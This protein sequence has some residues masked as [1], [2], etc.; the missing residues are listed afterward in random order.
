MYST[1]ETHPHLKLWFITSFFFFFL[2]DI[3]IL[4]QLPEL[5]AIHLTHKLFWV[6]F[7][8]CREGESRDKFFFFLRRVAYTYP[9][10]SIY[11]YTYITLIEICLFS[12]SHPPPSTSARAPLWHNLIDRSIWVVAL[13]LRPKKPETLFLFAQPKKKRKNTHTS[14][15]YSPF[16]I[17]TSPHEKKIFSKKKKKTK[18]RRNSTTKPHIVYYF[19]PSVNVLS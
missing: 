14:I 9:I 8:V 18:E 15:Y 6:F 16:P 12:L 19:I 7:C 2:L 11:L 10:L 13:L 5:S 3:Y 1:H 17:Y 4:W